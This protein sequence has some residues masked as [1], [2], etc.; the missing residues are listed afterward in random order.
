[1]WGPTGPQVLDTGELSWTPLDWGNDPANPEQ[2]SFSLNALGGEING[3]AR[4]N[5]L[6]NFDFDARLDPGS[7]DVDYDIDVGLSV[8]E[9]G[10]GSFTIQSEQLGHS[11]LLETR[12]PNIDVY[13]GG[14]FPVWSQSRC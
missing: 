1:M 5:G 6:L 3:T 10:D 7:I 2:A 12:S 8:F 14:R 4:T 9:S 11:G 13:S